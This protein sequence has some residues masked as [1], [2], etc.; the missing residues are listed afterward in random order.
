[1]SPY[2]QNLTNQND[3]DI[4]ATSRNMF[5]LNLII[6]EMSLKNYL[7]DSKTI[8]EKKNPSKTYHNCPVLI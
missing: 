1:M 7:N 3:N 8:T 6:N 2:L 5:F 4:K